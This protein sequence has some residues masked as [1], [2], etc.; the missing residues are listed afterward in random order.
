MEC[1]LVLCPSLHYSVTRVGI[2]AARRALADQVTIH[3]RQPTK[4]TTEVKS[5]VYARDQPFSLANKRD[6]RVRQFA[7]H[8]QLPMG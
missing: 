4:Q 3:P 6:M 7:A 2:D 1:W 5:F 8:L